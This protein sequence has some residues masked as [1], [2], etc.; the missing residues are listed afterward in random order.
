MESGTRRYAPLPPLAAPS[1]IAGPAARSVTWRACHWQLFI[2][3]MSSK[4]IVAMVVVDHMDPSLHNDYKDRMTRVKQ[5]LRHVRSSFS[6]HQ[7]QPETKERD[8]S[9]VSSPERDKPG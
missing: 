6:L 4:A 8:R 1:Y 7:S 5:Q 9:R 3:R 2:E